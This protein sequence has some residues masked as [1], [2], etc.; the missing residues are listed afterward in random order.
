MDRIDQPGAELQ[1]KL[2]LGLASRRPKSGRTK[3]RALVMIRR[4]SKPVGAGPARPVK[5]R[6]NKE[7]VA[8]AKKNDR[9]AMIA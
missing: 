2:V 6:S 1:E 4:R 8:D 5:Y 7:G 3:C 9:G